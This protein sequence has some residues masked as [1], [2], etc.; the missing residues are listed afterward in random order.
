LVV[1]LTAK[2]IYYLLNRPQKS[3]R[4]FCKWLNT[5]IPFSIQSGTRNKLMLEP[6]I[7]SLLDLEG[8]GNSIA[9]KTL[10]SLIFNIKEQVAPLSKRIHKNCKVL[11][12]LTNIAFSEEIGALIHCTIIK[13]TMALQDPELLSL[14]T[15]R[16][17]YVY[18]LVGG[19]ISIGFTELSVLDRTVQ[20]VRDDNYLID[21]L[22]GLYCLKP[23]VPVG[24]NCRSFESK[25]HSSIAK[26]LG[27]SVKLVSDSKNRGFKCDSYD[28]TNSLLC[29]IDFQYHKSVG[30]LELRKI[31]SKLILLGLFR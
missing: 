5:S 31:N 2:L 12:Q 4:D 25:V 14:Y 9:P 18:L 17:V 16:V 6:D 15:K 13:K 1:L 22:I 10:N 8:L 27:I 7:M 28:L 24:E 19:N 30:P 23:Q 20:H 3:E 21:K 29:L 26:S 11:F